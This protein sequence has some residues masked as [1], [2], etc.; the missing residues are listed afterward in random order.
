MEKFTY[1]RSYLRKL[2]PFE[3]AIP[4]VLSWGQDRFGGGG[5]VSIPVR[6]WSKGQ[7]SDRWKEIWLSQWAEQRVRSYRDLS[8]GPEFKWWSNDPRL[9]YRAGVNGGI[10]GDMNEEDGKT[11]PTDF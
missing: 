11:I 3:G 7:A 2:L 9:Y 1:R 8:I 4:W 10:V 6:V 5:I